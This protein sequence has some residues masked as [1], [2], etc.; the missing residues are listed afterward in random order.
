MNYEQNYNQLLGCGFVPFNSLEEMESFL[1][2]LP[3]DINETLQEIDK[4]NFH[5]WMEV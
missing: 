4:I 5:I 2:L 1:E 3:S